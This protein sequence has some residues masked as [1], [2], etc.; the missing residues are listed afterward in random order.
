MHQSSTSTTLIER[1]QAE[2][3]DAAAW[4]EFVARYR[5]QILE[6]C[7]SWGIQAADSDDV[8]QVVLVKL[9]DAIKG[10]E[11]GR[12]G[13]FR[14]W[15][16]TVTQNAWLDMAARRRALA[17]GGDEPA[18][19]RQ[20]EARTDLEERLAEAFDRERVEVAMSR[21]QGRVSLSMWE[22]FRLTALEGLT[23]PRAA[24]RLGLSV[25]NVYVAKHRVQNLLR[26]ELRDPDETGEYE[27]P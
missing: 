26:E 2:P 3:A 4:E 21:V 11:P 5:P 1:L 20:L 19:L 16:R 15:L 12:G 13:R 25:A 6:W 7:R 10:F 18:W 14:G 9:V 22:A 27:R 23:G 24:E 8:A 17:T